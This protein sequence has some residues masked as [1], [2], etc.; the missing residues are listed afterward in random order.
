MI[1]LVGTRGALAFVGLLSPVAVAATWWQLRA[2]DVT[3][4]HQDHEIDVLRAVPT[5]ALL[6]LPAVERLARALEPLAVDRGEV[7]FAQG[8]EGDRFFLIEA[9][10]AEVLGDGVAVTTLGPG[11][12]FGDIAL[13]RRIPRTATVR[14]L[15]DLHL[16][17]LSGDR[18][19]AVLTSFRPSAA[20]ASAQVDGQLH[21]YAP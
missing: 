10:S 12:G 8:D 1:H 3:V 11:D 21:R 15:T 14:A 20:A 19:L 4:S 13:L 17:A 7:V 2:L 6:P 16:M 18:F 9:G 5:F